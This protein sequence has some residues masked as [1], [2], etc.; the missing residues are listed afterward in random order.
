ME[1]REKERETERVLGSYRVLM[2]AQGGGLPGLHTITLSL[3]SGVP[4]TVYS[5]FHSGVN[6]LCTLIMK[7]DLALIGLALLSLLPSGYPQQTAEDAC[8]VQILVPGLK[9]KHP[10]GLP[11][12]TSAVRQE[13]EC[14]WHRVNPSHFLVST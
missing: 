8:S 13:P 7:R 11:K 10:P 5:F 12:A 9:G 4:V 14:D 1:R 6:V 3:D 2:L